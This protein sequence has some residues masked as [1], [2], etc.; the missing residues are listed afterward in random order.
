MVAA[1]TRRR[2]P[3]LRG[4][5][6]VVPPAC[7]ARVHLRA[8]AG[9]NS[10]KLSRPR[11]PIRHT[12]RMEIAHDGS[13]LVGG[14]RPVP[15]LPTQFS[16]YRWR[17]G[18]RSRGIR[19][20]L[21]HFVN[22]GIDGVW[23][24]P[25]YPSPMADHGYDVSDY[26][27]IDPIFGTLAD[28]DRLI[29]EMHERGLRL[30]LDLCRTIPRICIH[31]FSSRPAAAIPPCVTGMSGAIRPPMAAPRQLAQS[32]RRVPGLD[33]RSAHRAIL[34]AFLP[35]RATGSQLAQ[36]CRASGDARRAALVA[37]PRR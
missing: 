19:R 6:Q 11:G 33:F 24:S 27:G 29:A 26:C 34:P 10:R 21:D 36:S 5:W 2:L 14:R 4:C 16:G 35:A 37:G 28:F 3:T 1:A 23:I 7:C 32:R 30:I 18:W 25:I 20:R 15:S 8:S 17:W 31:G 22:L 12:K 9:P 13:P